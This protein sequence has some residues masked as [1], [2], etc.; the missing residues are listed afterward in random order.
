MT[1]MTIMTAD[2]EFSSFVF[3]NTIEIADGSASQYMSTDIRYYI[4]CAN[5]YF[6]MQVRKKKNRKANVAGYI[7]S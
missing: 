4:V 5:S 1:I 2:S 7:L 6:G 3:Y